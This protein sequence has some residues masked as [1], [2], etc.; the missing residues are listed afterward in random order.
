MYRLLALL[1]F[2]SALRQPLMRPRRQTAL[3]VTRVEVCTKRY[4]KKKGGERML[5]TFEALAPDGVSVERADMSHTEH[6]CF[7]ERV[8]VC[9]LDARRG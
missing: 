6:G 3:H 7:D 1:A 2:G 9:C 8:A 4:C 5:R